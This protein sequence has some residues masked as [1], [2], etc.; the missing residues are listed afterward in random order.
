MRD[1]NFFW[2]ND[3]SATALRMAYFEHVCLDNFV[4]TPGNLT[5]V[6]PV[7]LF[8]TPCHCVD[9]FVFAVLILSAS[10]T[11]FY[12]IVYL[13]S[14]LYMLTLQT[15]CTKQTT[16]RV[17]VRFL[18]LFL[19]STRQKNRNYDHLMSGYQEDKRVVKTRQHGHSK[20]QVGATLVPAPNTPAHRE[21]WII[22]QQAIKFN[23]SRALKKHEELCE[24]TDILIAGL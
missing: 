15:R 10:T 17:G 13:P 9:V 22:W 3:K 5:S 14:E 7:Q 20:Q 11:K 12:R 21:G 16:L 19:M 6:F 2:T 18:A 1:L 8:I 24:T 4:W 23:Y